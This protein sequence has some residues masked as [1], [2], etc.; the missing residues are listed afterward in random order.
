ML[1]P[2]RYWADFCN[3]IGRPELADDPRFIDMDARKE[4]A[5]ACVDILDEVFASRDYSD[6]CEVLKKAKGVWSPFQTPLEV[7]SDPQVAANGYLSDVEMANGSKLTLVT[8]PVQFD[9]QV[10]KPTRAPEHGEHTE[11][12]LLELGLSWDEISKLKESGAVG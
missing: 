12:A 5:P 4:N 10:Q 3:V 7:H 6:W 11:A 8:S 2:D 1:Q 9:E